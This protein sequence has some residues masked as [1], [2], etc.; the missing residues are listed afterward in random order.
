[1][2]IVKRILQNNFFNLILLLIILFVYK[3][4]FS[5]GEISSG[6]AAFYF[7]ENYKDFNLLPYS[8]FSYKMGTYSAI[9]NTFPYLYLPIRLLSP[10]NLPWSVLERII[11]YW[12]F[13]VISFG[14]SFLLAKVL[15]PKNQLSFLPPFIYLLNSYVLM[16]V[17]GGQ[18]SIAL[19][20]ALFPAV[21]LS[22]YLITTKRSSIWVIFGSLILALMIA[23]ELRIAM[24]SVVASGLFILWERRFTKNSFF[25]LLVA[26]LTALGLHSYWII[27]MLVF[28]SQ[29]FDSSFSSSGWLPFLSFA[30]FSNAI[31]LLHPL[32]P[33]NIF[34]KTYFMRPEFLL[35]PIIAFSSL[36]LTSKKENT[37]RRRIVFFV[38]LAV[39][40]AFLSKGVNQPF[41]GIN[42]WLFEKIPGF[43]LFRDPTKF[44]VFISLSYSLLIPFSVDRVVD[45]LKKF[46]LFAFLVRMGF[47]VLILVTLAPAFLGNIGGTLKE[48][49]IADD[50]MQLEQYLDSQKDYFRVLWV[51]VRQRFG[52]AS[53]NHPY[54]NSEDYVSDGMCFSPLCSLKKEMKSDW[55]SGCVPNERCYLKNLSYFLNP[56]TEAVLSEMSVKYVIVPYDQYGEI[57]VKD[58]KYDPSQR[59][60]IEAFLASIPWLERVSSIGKIAIFKVKNHK[61]HFWI[62]NNDAGVLWRRINPTRYSVRL[63]DLSNEVLLIFSERYDS[64][65]VARVEG[66]SIISKPYN[67]VFNS[68]SIPAT[69]ENEMIIE[70]YPQKY[71]CV[72]VFISLALIV[73]MVV[74]LIFS[75]FVSN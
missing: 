72:G 67:E 62:V 60:Q 6:D 55:L 42:S 39:V 71:V 70:F 37:I 49:P 50:Y 46:N 12:P 29:P 57:F 36:A 9:L 43:S 26:F 44:Y 64:R 34:G 7:R 45:K 65:W 4:W 23:F 74:R 30:K 53:E 28:R 52:Y 25:K 40:G 58:R 5:F 21:V 33:E 54:L 20:H 18:I 51:P 14:S 75:T 31:S 22:F 32:W 8:W 73:C 61:D 24:L 19:A 11:W 13:L 63:N 66:K 47:L 59:P 68:F 3:S 15:F 1:M 27:F 16:I 2:Q 35:L 41:G 69:G 56:K 38:L 10:F 17:G 48:R